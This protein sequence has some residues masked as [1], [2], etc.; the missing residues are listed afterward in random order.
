VP[1]RRA[2]GGTLE[3]EELETSTSF[4]GKTCLFFKV[5]PFGGW[6]SVRGADKGKTNKGLHS[7]VWG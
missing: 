7:Y 5:K 1:S 2:G 4:L 6:V 3:K